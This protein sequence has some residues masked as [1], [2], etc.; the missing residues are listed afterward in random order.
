MNAIAAIPTTDA[1]TMIPINAGLERPLEDDSEP[2]PAADTDPEAEEAVLETVTTEV[3][4]VR[5]MDDIELRE[6]GGT[7]AEDEGTEI[8]ETPPVGWTWLVCA[9]D[10]EEDSTD[11]LGIRDD[12]DSG[13][14]DADEEIGGVVAEDEATIA[15]LLSAGLKDDDDSAVDDAIADEELAGR[16]T[17]E[18]DAETGG[19]DHELFIF[20]LPC[21]C[22]S[23]S[24]RW[25][26]R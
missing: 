21:P 23:T 25:S 26:R 6:V 4:E 19:S 13:T 5:V 11:E 7:V 3:I 22:L 16:L 2:A 9:I 12:D 8:V 14:G 15:E 1:P 18:D 10:D 20:G 17:V 24:A